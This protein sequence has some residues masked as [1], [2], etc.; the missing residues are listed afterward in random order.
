MRSEQCSNTIEFELCNK[1]R[2]FNSKVDLVE[3]NSKI[4]EYEYN[5]AKKADL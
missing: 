1:G 2:C 5:T 3:A 4:V